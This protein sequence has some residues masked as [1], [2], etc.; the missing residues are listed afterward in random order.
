[1]KQTIYTNYKLHLTPQGKSLLR[2]QR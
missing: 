2:V 1:M